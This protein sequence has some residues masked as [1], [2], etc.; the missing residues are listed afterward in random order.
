MRLPVR[1]YVLLIMATAAAVTVVDLTVV[2][3]W[4]HTWTPFSAVVLLSLYVIAVH[5]VVKVHS[6]WTTDASTVPAVATALLLPPGIAV[7]IAGVSLVTYSII[8]RRL[9]LKGVFNAASA[10]LAVG[11]AAHIATALGGP[12][13]LTNGSGWKALAAAGRDTLHHT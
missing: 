8:R 7:L 13:E 2:S 12:T 5:F 4:T 9:G 11:S 3:N 10:M 1:V 6:G